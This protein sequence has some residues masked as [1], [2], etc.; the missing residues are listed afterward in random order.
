MLNQSAC[1][2]EEAHAAHMAMNGECPWCGAVKL[3]VDITDV[4]QSATRIN[5]TE[6]AV[7]DRVFDVFGGTHRVARV[8]KKNRVEFYRDDQPTLRESLRND[9][10][11]TVIREGR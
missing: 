10:T 2:Y 11:I 3:S 8:V 9:D 6:L 7:G 5:A 1:S 4:E